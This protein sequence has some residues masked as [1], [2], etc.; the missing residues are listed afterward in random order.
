MKIEVNMFLSSD[1]VGTAS[2]NNPVYGI[3]RA[4]NKKRPEEL[5]FESKT[6][7]YELIV[8][9]DNTKLSWIANATSLRVLAAKYGTDS[10]RWVDKKIRLWSVE[11]D[12]LGRMRKIVYAGPEI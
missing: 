5:P 6:E 11:Q 9:I 2:I 4:I 8:E 1:T 3:I 7:R 10:D 12:V